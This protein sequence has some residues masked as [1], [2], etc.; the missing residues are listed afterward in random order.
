[1][2]SV[3]SSVGPIEVRGGATEAEVAAIVAAIE[4]TW[5]KPAAP[6]AKRPSQSTA[7]RHADRWWAAGRLPS[8]WK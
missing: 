4:M 6:A 7:W 5:P 3:S 1:M 2:A 8:S